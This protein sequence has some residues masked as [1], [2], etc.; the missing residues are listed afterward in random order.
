MSKLSL[1][2]FFVIIT[3]LVGVLAIGFYFSKRQKSTKDYFIANKRIPGWAMGFALVATIVSNITFLANA[4]AAYASGWELFTNSFM[5]FLVIWPIV[6]IA[7]PFYRNVIGIS[8][9]EYLEKRFG[10]GVRAYGS[11]AFI[12]YYITRLGVIFFVLSL[13]VSTMTGWNIY[14]IILMLGLLTLIYTFMGGIEAV[15]W[16]EVGQGILLI[17]GG[18]VCLGIIFSDVPEGPD[19]ILSKAWEEGKFSLGEMSFNLKDN[20]I[21][22]MILYGLYQHGHNFGTDQIMVQR[23]LTA[24]TTR[25]SMRGALISGIACVPVWGMFFL[26]GTALWVYYN[27]TLNDLPPEIV[28][29]PDQVFPYFIMTKLPKGVTGL[30]L[31]ALFSSAMSTISGGLNSIST[32][33]TTDLF[34]RIYKEAESRTRLLVARLVVIVTGILSLILAIWFVTRT[35]QALDHY[36]M[37]L[38]IFGGGILGLFLLAAL[39]KKANLH[40]VTIAIIVNI[41]VTAW[42]SLTSNNVIDLGAFNYTLHPFLIGLVSHIT[43]FVVG[44]LAS[45]FFIAKKEKEISNY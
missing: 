10:Y 24:R 1:I 21:A 6:F 23:Y 26:I 22:V 40:G 37:A 7:I 27:F 31:V 38:S 35:G 17:G 12:L 3:Y 8:L 2:D 30:I 18:L 4:G 11:I 9:Y 20:T 5:V 14:F 25:E 15:T 45:L 42:A 41:I 13:A 44:Y 36:F 33:F 43:I 39:V 29:N 16:T 19:F 34:S 32:V 28:G